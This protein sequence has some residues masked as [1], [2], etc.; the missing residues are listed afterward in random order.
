MREALSQIS[1]LLNANCTLP[2]KHLLTLNSAVS[3]T[4]YI[5]DAYLGYAAS[6]L[7][8]STVLRSIAGATFPLFAAN[9]YTALG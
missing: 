6:A 8:A 5:V 1:D 4:N 2:L 3:L 7:A 9:L